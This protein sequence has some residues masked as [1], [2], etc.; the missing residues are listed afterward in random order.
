[1]LREFAP[2]KINLFLHVLGR[3]DDGYHH[4]ESLVSFADIGDE[5]SL[6]PGD[7]ASLGLSGPFSFGLSGNDNLVM[8]AVRAFSASFGRVKTGRFH[9]IKNLPV[10]SGI[11]G[12]SSD[13][14][15]ALRLLAEANGIPLSDHRIFDAA[16]TLGADVPVCLDPAAPRLMQGIGHELGNRLHGFR[17]PALLVN[18][19][20]PIETQAVFAALGLAN[21]ERHKPEKPESTSSKD[22]GL[23]I[24]AATRN[25]L[26]EA[27]IRIAPDILEVLQHLRSREG[28]QFARMSGS[29]ATCFAIFDSVAR[30]Q[31]AAE[32]INRD[33][34]DWWAQTCFIKLPS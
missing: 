31:H 30:A 16:R 4:L 23:D 13:A 33:Q 18:P 14:A 15:A 25:D 2:A 3:R 12:G 32:A 9:L 27:A 10:A 7:A 29:G 1:M 20:V 24:L 22:G 21:G 11:G 17:Y 26:E 28:C 34:P 8:K 5:L 6:E 19:G